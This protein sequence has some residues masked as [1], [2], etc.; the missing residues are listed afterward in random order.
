MPCPSPQSDCRDF[1]SRTI[2][3]I[4]PGRMTTAEKGVVDGFAKAYYL[5]VVNAVDYASRNGYDFYMD[6]HR[7]FE[8]YCPGIPEMIERCRPRLVTQYSLLDE[9]DSL[10]RRRRGS[11][12]VSKIHKLKPRVS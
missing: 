11:S 2:L 9:S 8:P 6:D 12:I 1:S 7:F 3:A 10:T 4:D 5:N